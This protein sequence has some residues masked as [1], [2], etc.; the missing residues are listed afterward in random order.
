MSQGFVPQGSFKPSSMGL[1]AKS[2]CVVQNAAGE[3]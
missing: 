1:G 3:I 2:F